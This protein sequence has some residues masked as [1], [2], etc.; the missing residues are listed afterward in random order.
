MQGWSW[1]LGKLLLDQNNK[2]S[3]QTLR[4]SLFCG[5]FF[6]GSAPELW[7]VLLN[8]TVTLVF[9]LSCVGSILN[10]RGVLGLTNLL[11]LRFYLSLVWNSMLALVIIIGKG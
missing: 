6:G 9:T 3:Y 5:Q 8:N 10:Q 2:L 4:F 1:D 11:H 7:I